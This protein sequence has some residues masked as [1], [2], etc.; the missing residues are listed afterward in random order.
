MLRRI[1]IWIALPA[2]LG[3]LG[4]CGSR[5]GPPG[6]WPLPDR[7]ATRGD[8]RYLHYDLDRDGRLDYVQRVR[9][10]YVDRLYFPPASPG[11]A[12]QVIKRPTDDPAGGPLL[13]LLLDGVAYER[14]RSLRE[15]GRFR[16]FRPPTRV[17]S[18]FPSL[19][20][21]AYDSFLGTGPTPGYEA[22]F[23]DRA[24]NRL[25]D[26]AGVYLRG[27]NE[28][29]VRHVHYRL[30]F[31][32]DVFMYLFPV[33]T[34]RGELHRA[35][36]ALDERL[37]S[38]NRVAVVYILSTDALGH[39]LDREQIEVQ[40]ETLDRWLERA[41]Y[42]RRGELEIVVLADHSNSAGAQR[43]FQVLRLLR[44]SGLRVRARLERPGDV[45][46][47][48]FGLLDMV[49]F[50]TYD[51]TTRRRLIDVL[52]SRPEV[53][54]LAWPDGDDVRV[55]GPDG[56][57][58]IVA[59]SAGAGREYR[60]ASDEGDPLKLESALAELRTR[61]NADPEGFATA[62]AWLTATVELAY[63]A[64]PPRIWDGLHHLSAERPD[65]IASLS[66]GWYVGS[67]FFAG[68]VKLQGTHGGLHR[69]AS[70]SFA[71]GTS[72]DLTSPM[73]LEGLFERVRERY[74]WDPGAESGPP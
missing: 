8:D 64:G 52:L 60:Y 34:F 23:F 32:R 63:P 26:G 49:R 40:L 53:E 9:D 11:A 57:A 28:R 27:E 70:E 5:A 1:A 37:R 74:A 72:L 42:E 22:A 46:V 51:D 33:P 47:P 56:T 19:T 29:W 69:R 18:T 14:I 62:A 39:M 41:L 21:L 17:I 12:A 73:S 71:M 3:A 38:G 31:F 44:D 55:A 66:S 48:L 15:R 35:R 45:V 24:A 54:L 4:A 67:G 20:D 13:V 30:S 43:R 65:L 58:R 6:W 25:T 61:Q 36:H 50:H 59:R 68:F 2:A 10:G 16:L 7:T